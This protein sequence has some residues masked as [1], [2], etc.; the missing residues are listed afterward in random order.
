[1]FAA[2]LVLL[3]TV[4][5][6]LLQHATALGLP[7][8]TVSSP[9]VLSHY[10]PE[11][12]PALA[13]RSDGNLFVWRDGVLFGEHM[14]P[15]AIEARPIGIVTTAGGTAV[16]TADA[17]NI[18]AADGALTERID[19]SLLPE[20]PQAIGRTTGGNLALRGGDGAYAASADFLSFAPIDGETAE[21]SQAEEMAGNALP[22]FVRVTP[23]P[24]MPLDRVLLDLHTGRLFGTAGVWI[25]NLGT[26]A[27][28]ALAITGVV[29]ALRRNSNGKR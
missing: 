24:G 7:H 26:F 1:L 16:A 20:A 12:R 21:W 13:F 3:V 15:L 6:L 27:F 25:V 11:N 29:T 14:T 18:L 4:T 23:A 28:L 19:V 22:A 9:A 10:F 2:I 5:G 17:L 8:I